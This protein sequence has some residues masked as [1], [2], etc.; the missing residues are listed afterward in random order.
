MKLRGDKSSWEQLSIKAAQVRSTINY[1]PIILSFYIK[2]TL[3][4]ELRRLLNDGNQLHSAI[5]ELLMLF[6]YTLIL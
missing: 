4:V 3:Y 1:I 6:N 5:S 2:V